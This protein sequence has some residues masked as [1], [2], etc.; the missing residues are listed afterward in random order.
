MNSRF[1]TLNVK[2]FA[3]GLLVAVLTAV[4]TIIYNTVQAS[5]L[6]F[7]WKAIGTVALASAIGYIVKNLF[8]NSNN[9]I[10]KKENKK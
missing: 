4:V 2:D 7:D 1:L 10:F 9:E 6:D 3:K 5:S 8:T